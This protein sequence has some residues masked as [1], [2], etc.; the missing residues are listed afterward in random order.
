MTHTDAVTDTI[1]MLLLGA[2]TCLGSQLFVK[3]KNMIES[4]IRQ[5]Y[6][7]Q[8]AMQF[9]NYKHRWENNIEKS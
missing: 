3:I 9:T 5:R 6:A 4:Q 7:G 8:M 1:M 2:D